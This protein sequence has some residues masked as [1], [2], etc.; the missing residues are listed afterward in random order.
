MQQHPR[1]RIVRPDPQTA[2]AISRRNCIIEAA[3]AE[4]EAARVRIIAERAAMRQAAIFWLC[5]FAG[6][7][8]FWVAVIW[9]VAHR[10][11]GL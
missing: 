3:A 11:M 2:A 5:L 10:E 4:R 1:L 7:I 6:V 8:A 9:S